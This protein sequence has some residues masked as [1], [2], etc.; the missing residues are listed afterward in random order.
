[1]GRES[2]PHGI[3]AAILIA[4]ANGHQRTGGSRFL[5]RQQPKRQAVHCLVHQLVVNRAVIIGAIR[6]ETYLIGIDHHLAIVG[7]IIGREN[8]RAAAV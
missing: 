1:M 4:C 5:H 2:C 3:D 7:K 6:K 8:V